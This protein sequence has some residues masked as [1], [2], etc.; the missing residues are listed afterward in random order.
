MQAMPHRLHSTHRVTRTTVSP[1]TLTSWS[2]RRF[3][4]ALATQ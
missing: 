3:P 1:F 2:S 4:L